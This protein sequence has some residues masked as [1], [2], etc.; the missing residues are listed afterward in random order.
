[1]DPIFLYPAAAAQHVMEKRMEVISNN[2][3]NV[4]T[5]GFRKD[6]PIFASR[7][8]ILA[9]A[10]S[11]GGASDPTGGNSLLPVPYYPAVDEVVTDFSQGVSHVT[12]NP[13]DIA[14]AGKGFFQIQTAGGIRYT[15][16]GSFRLSPDGLIVTQSGEPVLG[17]GGP[18][19]LP[20]GTTLIDEDG[21][22]SVKGVE[23]G[24]PV[25]V[26][27]LSLINIEDPF[28]LQKIGDN[29][30]NIISANTIPFEGKLRQ[31][32]L[33][34]SNVNPITE[35]VAMILAM[36]QYEAVQKAM[37]GADDIAT[38]SANQVGQLRA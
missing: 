16:N 1:M 29:L 19:S 2:L 24:G 35:M 13:L 25:T 9:K 11:L 30:F 22:V 31:G 37:H 20:Q 18:I 7:T 34:G 21:V 12:N 23:G 27:Q 26:G 33:E 5:T 10:H 3:A 38:K 8:A 36:R 15:R 17:E 6:F 14:I 32:V 4:S 28:K